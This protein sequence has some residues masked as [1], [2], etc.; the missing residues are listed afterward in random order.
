LVTDYRPG[1]NYVICDVCGFRCRASETRKRWDG[2]RVCDADYETRHPQD[3]VR[4]RHDRQRAVITRPE[5]PDVFITI[6]S[7]VR[8]T[9]SDWVLWSDG[10]PMEWSV[11]D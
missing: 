4:G 3:F 6:P 8:W 7:Y 10:E 9:D 1:D 5:P 2:L 11:E